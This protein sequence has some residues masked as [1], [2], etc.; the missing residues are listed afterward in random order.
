MQREGIFQGKVGVKGRNVKIQVEGWRGPSKEVCLAVLHWLQNLVKALVAVSKRTRC[1]QSEF[2][3]RS[4]RAV[5]WFVVADWPRWPQNFWERNRSWIGWASIRSNRVMTN[6]LQRFMP[7]EVKRYVHGSRR[8]D[9][10]IC[11]NDVRDL[12]HLQDHPSVS[13]FVILDDRRT[14]GHETC[15]S[16]IF[17][18]IVVVLFLAG[19][20]LMGFLF[21]LRVEVSDQCG[22]PDWRHPACQLVHVYEFAVLTCRAVTSG[23]LMWVCLLIWVPFL[24]APSPMGG[25]MVFDRY[26]RACLGGADFKRTQK[27]VSGQIDASRHADTENP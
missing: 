21:I 1:M 5:I 25:S 9:S 19:L 12:P 27:L 14:A 17:L 22:T 13:H 15:S 24:L 11:A 18:S 7:A 3:L 23:R 16:S 2:F 8:R 20:L 26:F 10:T 6:P 4:L